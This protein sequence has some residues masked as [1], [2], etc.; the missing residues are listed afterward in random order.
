MAI[1]PAAS[2]QGMVPALIGTVDCHIRV[3]VQEHDKGN[4]E[5]SATGAP[6]AV[7]FATSADNRRIMELAYSAQTFGRPYMLAPGVPAERVAA[8]RQAFMATMRD[9]ELLA[10]ARRSSLAIDPISG[11]ELQALA[12][13]IFATPA[14]LVERTRRAMTYKIP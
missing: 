13:G 4:P 10:D 14:D 9:A 8:L 3:L 2:G 6:L 1:C 12:A 11:A 5:I 7:D